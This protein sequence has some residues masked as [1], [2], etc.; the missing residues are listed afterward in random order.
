MRMDEAAGA[1][2]MM[3]QAV[4]VVLGGV[5]GALVNNAFV[6]LLMEASGLGLEAAVE[7]ALRPGRYVVA[8]AVAALLPFVARLPGLKAWALALVLLTAIPSLLAKY[9][10]TPDAPWI[11]LLA[12]NLVYAGAATATYA[13]A[14]PRRP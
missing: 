12:A 8:I 14:A 9:V 2:A 6:G 11:W 7:L 13:L 4:A 3:R 1:P 10:F 5:V